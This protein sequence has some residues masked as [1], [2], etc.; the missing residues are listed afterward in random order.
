MAEARL[1]LGRGPRDRTAD[2]WAALSRAARWK[3]Q[4]RE[5]AYLTD[6]LT[7]H[8]W[9]VED[10][11]AGLDELGLVGKLFDTQPFF[12]MHMER[13]R[14]L[15]EKIEKDCYG[16]T[17]GLYLHYEPPAPR[18]MSTC[19]AERKIQSSGPRPGPPAEVSQTAPSRPTPVQ[20]RSGPALAAVWRA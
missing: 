19:R 17:F 20:P 10:I 11:A 13:A 7:S 5:R 6:F 8:E 2:E 18:S 1:H 14:K 15:V 3:A 16:E 9:R 12:S 4:Q